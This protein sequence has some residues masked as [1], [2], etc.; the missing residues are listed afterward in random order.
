ML[1]DAAPPV[2]LTQRRLAD[3]L[4]ELKTVRRTCIDERS[5]RIRRKGATSDNA[6]LRQRGE[7][8][9]LITIALL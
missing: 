9:V 7:S 4:P 8:P 3:R 2:L 5:S 6:P 1:E